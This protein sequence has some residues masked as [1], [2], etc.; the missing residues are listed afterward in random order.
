MTIE[1]K[2]ELKNLYIGMAIINVI[3]FAITLLWGFSLSML[4]GL[5]IGY[6]FMC[7]NMYYLGHTISKAVYRQKPNNKGFM[8][9]NYALRYSILFILVL[10]AFFVDFINPV[11]IILP[12]FYPRV[13]LTINSFR[14]G[15][16]VDNGNN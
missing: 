14:K 6:A 10:V 2:N 3:V 7:W 9:G 16:G 1:I 11:G 8:V 5:I 4:I 12:L 13:V 15:K